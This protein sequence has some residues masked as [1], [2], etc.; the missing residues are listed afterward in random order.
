MEVNS[1]ISNTAG[2]MSVKERT[3][4]MMKVLGWDYVWKTYCHHN[5]LFL[6]IDVLREGV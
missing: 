6:M 3:Y 4:L 5:G 2:E 1:G